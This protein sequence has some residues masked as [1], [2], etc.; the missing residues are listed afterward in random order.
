MKKKYFTGLL[1]AMCFSSFGQKLHVN[2]YELGEG[3]TVSNDRGVSTNLGFMVQPWIEARD[4]EDFENVT[5]RMRLRR[6]RAT[7]KGNFSSRLSYR[8]RY[9]FTQGTGN[10]EEE[11]LNGSLLDALIKFKISKNFSITAGQKSLY[12]DNRG[13]KIIASEQAFIERSRVVSSFASIRDIGLF[14]EGRHHIR[15][16]HRLKTFV[17]I[18]SGDGANNFTKNHGGLKYGGRVQYYPH[19]YFRDGGDFTEMDNYRELRPKVAFGLY[20]NYNDGMSSRRGRRSG[21]LLYFDTD[22]NESLPDYA[23]FG[24]DVLFKYSGFSAMFEATHAMAF[25]PDDI[26][27]Y[28]R[29]NGSLKDYSLGTT[30]ERDQEIKNRIM[31]GTI[32]NIQAVY[33]LPSNLGFGVRWSQQQPDEFSYMASSNL[34]YN[35]SD[36]FT[37]SVLKNFNKAIKI[38][39]DVTIN[40]TGDDAYTNMNEEYPTGTGEPTNG[41]NEI[42]IRL[43]TQLVF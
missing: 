33:M 6:A 32:F 9:E 26:R 20:G 23:Q 17:E 29:T 41:Q 27:Y 19:G 5:Y 10:N 25:I 37:I 2:K 24:G 15:G 14:L 22:L 3:V 13:M 28:Q 38:M 39:G 18:V 8:L 34:Y 1:L 16:S 31:L 7:L 30:E 4:T 35:R 12:I 11:L 42:T 43:M 36:Y 21:T 40:T